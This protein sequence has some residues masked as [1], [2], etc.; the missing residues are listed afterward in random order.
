MTSFLKQIF[1]WWNRQTVGT[2]LYTL[3]TGKFVGTDEFDNKYY[4][5]S[6]ITY[7]QI[8]FGSSNDGLHW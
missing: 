3:F 4:I 6:L 8:S 1:T 2:F 5:N 7:E